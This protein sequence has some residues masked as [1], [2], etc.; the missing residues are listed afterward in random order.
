MISDN[1]PTAATEEESVPETFGHWQAFVNFWMDSMWAAKKQ[2]NYVK[3]ALVMQ[4]IMEREQ[5][6][7]KRL[8]D[9]GFWCDFAQVCQRRYFRGIVS[10]LLLLFV[11]LALMTGTAKA[12]A[13]DVTLTYLGT[14]VLDS[15]GIAVPNNAYYV[16][17]AGE[18]LTISIEVTFVD[19]AVQLLTSDSYCQ[20]KIYIVGSIELIEVVSVA[21][22]P[23]V[24]TFVY[25]P[26]VNR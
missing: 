9:F 2:R 16:D 20:A 12:N 8:D 17:C 19:G 26:L 18:Q 10:M 23:D 25:L 6:S 13:E 11:A 22:G 1:F 4:S 5:P 7:Y 15:N 24:L 21:G 14:E 3:L